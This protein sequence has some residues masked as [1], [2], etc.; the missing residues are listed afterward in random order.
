VFVNV[1]VCVVCFGRRDILEPMVFF[2]CT[3]FN[4]FFQLT[5]ELRYENSETTVVLVIVLG[6]DPES[7]IGLR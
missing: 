3:H 4:T 7:F 5:S 2:A 1:G 6:I